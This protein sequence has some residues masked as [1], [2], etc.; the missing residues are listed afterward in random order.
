LEAPAVEAVRYEMK[1][2]AFF[3][4]EWRIMITEVLLEHQRNEV[5]HSLWKV[6]LSSHCT[7]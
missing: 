2:P 6:I 1:S 4:L 5:S 3:I 7:L